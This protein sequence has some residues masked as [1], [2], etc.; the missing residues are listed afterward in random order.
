[1][2][3]TFLTAFILLST[4]PGPAQTPAADPY[5]PVYH[6]TAPKNWINDANGL[7]YTNGQYQLFYQY[8]PFSADP[9]HLSWGHATSPDLLRWTPQPVALTEYKNADGSNTMIFSGSAVADKDNTSGLFPAG[10][11]DGLV[12]FYTGHV[13]RPGVVLRQHQNLATSLDHGLT[14]QRYAGNPVLDIGS[15][16]FRDPKV[17][18]YAPQQKWVMA[19]VKADRQQVYFYES[20]NLKNWTFLSRW[21]RAGDTVREWECPDLFELPVPGGGTRWVLLISAGNPTEQFRGQQY[22][23]GQFDGKVFTPDQPYDE[24]TYID[25]GKDFFA[26]VTFNDAPD[27][28][29]ILVG[30]TNDWAYARDVPTGTEWRGNFAVPRELSLRRTTAGLTLVQQPVPE[31][32]KLGKDA[33]NVK[34]RALKPGPTGYEVPFRGESYDLELTLKPGAAQVL[35]LNVLQSEAERTTLRYN[36]ARQ[37]LTL[38]RTGSG[39]VG[40]HPLFA[41]T[42]E[43]AKVPL[44]NGLLHLRLLVDKSVVEVFAQN[45]ETTLT[46]LVFP[47]QHTG[48]ITLTTEGGA[49][50][51]TTLRLTDLSQL[52][53]P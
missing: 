16:E 27:N 3:T 11:T 45:G 44:Q 17:F 13:E 31:L 12:A 52:T 36:V 21:G 53:V 26:G 15:K 38:D 7:I 33:L 8:N 29:R 24:P 49:A 14:W 51:L 4:L 43:T 10:T 1:M 35:T 5:R 22:F 18:W 50:Q 41:S 19:T 28:R 9:G 46:D 42:L 30:W 39:N 23:L 20:K 32:R 47:R 34:N 25:Y 37:T 2:K 6:F 40:F 48:R